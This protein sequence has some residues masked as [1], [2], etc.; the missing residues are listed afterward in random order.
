MSQE[1]INLTSVLNEQIGPLQYD[2]EG[3]YPFR[4][5]C[6][7]KIIQMRGDEQFNLLINLE[8]VTQYLAENN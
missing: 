8:R 1:V 7:R 6:G 2:E 4:M 5:I 3:D